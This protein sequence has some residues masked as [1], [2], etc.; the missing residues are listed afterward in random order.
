MRARTLFVIGLLF[1]GEIL[2][3]ALPGHH[4]P[5]TPADVGEL[6]VT[7]REWAVPSKE[8]IR[9]ILLSVRMVRSGSP[10]K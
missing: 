5:R 4:P 10:N 6:N 1:L 8:L 7:I 2:A 3:L 9:T